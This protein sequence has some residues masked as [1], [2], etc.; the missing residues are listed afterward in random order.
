MVFPAAVK[1]LLIILPL[2]YAQGFINDEPYQSFFAP[3]SNDAPAPSPNSPPSSSPPLVPALFVIG[4]SS[5]DCGTHTFLGKF[6]RADRLPYG[7]DFD[8]HQPTGRFCNGRIP[9][10][11][12]GKLRTG[13]CHEFSSWFSFLCK[14]FCFT[15]LFFLES[16]CICTEKVEEL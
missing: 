16:Q 13:Y 7:R 3:V 15:F 4:D 12:L 2:V 1:A 9:V 10:D 8:T 6:A 11:F 5:V 14:N